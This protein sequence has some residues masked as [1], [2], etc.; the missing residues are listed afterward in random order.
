[1]DKEK[2]EHHANF[3]ANNYK[4][5]LQTVLQKTPV[6]TL[7]DLLK[8]VTYM[9]DSSQLVGLVTEL[10]E[11]L[12][13][14]DENADEPNKW[15]LF[16][17]RMWLEIN[18][19][20]QVIIQH[21]FTYNI[22]QALFASNFTPLDTEYK[23]KLLQ[24]HKLTPKKLKDLLLR[25]LGDK[26]FLGNVKHGGSKSELDSQKKLRFLAYYNRY[27]I[28]IKN[29]RKEKNRLHRKEKKS[30]TAAKRES[31]KKYE[32][33]QRL[34]NS[35]FSSDAPS[36][37][38]L[39][40]ALETLEIKVTREYAKK[41][42]NEIRKSDVRDG[43][44]VDIDYRIGVRIYRF[45]PDNKQKAELLRY[46]PPSQTHYEEIDDPRSFLVEMQF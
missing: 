2:A 4:Q 40:W 12:K 10:L 35:T 19:F 14:F 37:V 30:E 36:E 44:L 11:D 29:A 15:Q 45:N 18:H 16:E 27:L 24:K 6:E 9:N 3:L 28:V 17:G 46:V 20:Q 1:M 7:E 33:P 13:K 41:L 23:K 21:F 26:S 42:L 38:A 5:Q 25:F 39:D 22:L 43:T 31:L 8:T 34:S 32:I